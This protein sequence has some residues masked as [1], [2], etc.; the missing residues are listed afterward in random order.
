MSETVAARWEEY[1]EAGRRSVSLGQSAE[2][3]ELF[4]A[5]VREGE[6]LGADSPHLATS[7]NALGQLRLQAKDLAEAEL[8]FS[9]ALA[10]RER[11]YGPESHAIVPSLN[12][13]AAVREAQG[14]TDIAVELLRRSLAI[15]EQALG[16]SHP[17]VTLVVNNLAKLYFR[18]RDFSKADRLLLRL[19]ET[20]RAL[21][22]DHP[23]VATVLGSLAKLRQAV[24]KHA[25]A[26]KLWRQALAIRERAFA[27]NDPILATTLENV[28]DCCA[29][30]ETGLGE[31]IALRV[32]A[33][34][35]REATMGAAH[36]ALAAA[37]AKLDELRARPGADAA[38]AGAAP[39]PARTSQEIPS[40][41]LS[42]EVPPFGPP[43]AGAPSP[44]LPWIQ[45]DPEPSGERAPLDLMPTE[46]PPAATNRPFG[47]GRRSAPTPRPPLVPP[48]VPALP[49][50]GASDLIITDSLAPEPPV[51]RPPERSLQPA[52]A[53]PPMRRAHHTPRASSPTRRPPEHASARPPRPPRRSRKGLVFGTLLLAVGGGGWV[54][55]TRAAPQTASRIAAP[56][57]AEAA[58]IVHEPAP[59]A[60]TR[61][62]SIAPASPSVGEVGTPAAPK[63]EHHSTSPAPA[64]RDSS[65]PKTVA[66]PKQDEQLSAPSIPAPID[67]DAVTRSIDQ[68]TKAKVDSVQKLRIEDKA[69]IFKKP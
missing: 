39:T 23:E 26:E 36:P 44:N 8:C 7:L 37:R 13:L 19:L 3:E 28:A 12:N 22:R 9:R 49:L 18:R 61:T 15:S 59:A 40:P 17:E 57:R 21:G 62:D 56:L 67:V 42:H 29:A 43:P 52:A 10:I 34:A 68:S 45:V 16:A 5:A 2:A 1:N 4:R 32:R 11:T 65:V 14:T 64:S 48:A 51:R 55:L 53:A 33:M 60:V 69:P 27:P 54:A 31:A 50:I 46:P 66:K 25:P 35:I 41:L 6:Q 30:Q 58:A 38:A 63:P 24:G 20:K 47:G